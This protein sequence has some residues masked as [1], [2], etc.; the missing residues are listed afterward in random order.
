MKT[1][2]VF[3]GLASA[4]LTAF[5]ANAQDTSA[6]PQKVTVAKV[7]TITAD[8]ASRY[9]G[10]VE[11]V[12]TV[13]LVA[14]VEGY[15]DK[16]NFTEGGTVK[17]GDLLYVIEKDLYQASVDQSKA[18][19]EGAKATLENSQIELERQRQLLAKGDISQANFDKQK[20]TTATDQANVDGAQANLDT[21]DINLGYTEIYSPIDGRISKTNV[22][23][24]NLVDS[25]TGTLATVTSVDP[26]YVS[27]YMGEKDLIK[28]R[29][30]G[31]IGNDSAT[32]KVNL[33]MA[34]GTQYPSAGKVT[35]VGT[36]VDQSSDTV[37]LRATFDNPKNL[38]IPGQFVNV[39][40]EAADPAKLA[41]VPQTAIQLDA[42]GHF[43]Y[44]VD[45]DN[46]VK[47]QDIQLG[48]QSGSLW[49]VKS[50][51]KEGEQVIVQGLQRVKPDMT[52]APVEAKS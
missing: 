31:L 41:A 19:L 25:N 17:K 3:L 30:A 48:R 51:L 34:N 13:D 38:L 27:F 43:V 6:Q 20:A 50:G 47:R 32:L 40:V 4:I 8:N 45:S 15:L 52:V 21:A 28:D 29:E 23:V 36:T 42:K 46:K 1:A 14:R 9:V 26:I 2:K 35:Y 39:T 12:S 7:S 5:A 11:A 16:R 10:R 37:E 44:V 24:G 18:T 33:T 49:E 22:N